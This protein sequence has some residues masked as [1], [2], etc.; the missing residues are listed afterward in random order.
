MAGRYFG[1]PT[2]RSRP[3]PV[4]AAARL[5]LAIGFGAAGVA[6]AQA[7]STLPHHAETENRVVDVLAEWRRGHYG[8][9]ERM[10]FRLKSDRPDFRLA[11]FL[12]A[13]L[14]RARS[15]RADI[16]APPASDRQHALIEEARSRWQHRRFRPPPEAVPD[17]VLQLAPVFRHVLVAD[18]AR[19]RLYVFRNGEAGLDLVAD[20]YA[21]IGAAGFGKQFEGDLRT[22]L[23][24]YH[25]TEFKPDDELPELYGDGAFPVDYPNSWDRYYG[26]TGYGIWV[27][28]VP[29]DTYNRAPR[30]SE[31]CVVVANSDLNAL[32]EYIRPGITPIVFAEQLDWLSLD[33][34]AQAR[35][36]VRD[37]V[38]AWQQ[39]RNAPD[40][41]DRTRRYAANF[42]SADGLGR[43]QFVRLIRDDAPALADLPM[44][45]GQVS[46][47][48]YPGE[49]DLVLVSFTRDAGVSTGSP[50]YRQQYW[51]RQPD[52]GW[53]I[54]HE[55]VRAE[56]QTAMAP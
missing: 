16:W 8:R 39:D 34:A 19:N 2:N 44:D 20:F 33:E 36:E 10:L 43:Q 3:G 47:Y 4:V 32:H 22:P 42:V 54:I 5:W 53:Q 29:R 13:E 12:H 50:V 9:V 55:A 21:S 28:G 23:G 38:V 31:G 24:V 45:P 56:D 15:G 17:A 7:P 6:A 1:K 52:G 37:A 35:R 41:P 18:L 40:A 30:A 49:S 11:H 46:I 27:H 14:L 48:R 25:V 26:R 51:R